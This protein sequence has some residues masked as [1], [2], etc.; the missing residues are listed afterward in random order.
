MAGKYSEAVFAPVLPKMRAVELIINEI[1]ALSPNK[2][3]DISR[4]QVLEIELI[5][6]QGDNFY[7]QRSYNK[8]LDKFREARAKIYKLLYPPFDIYKF[9]VSQDKMLPNTIA[10][11]KKIT[12]MSDKM[13]NMVLPSLP[14]V[15][16]ATGL[17]VDPQPDNIKD[18]M[19]SGLREN[20]DLSDEL[21]YSA[22]NGAAHMQNRNYKAAIEVMEP[23][24]KKAQQ[25]PNADGNL[26]AALELNLAIANLQSDQL[27]N[28]ETLAKQAQTNFT[29]LKDEVG[30]SQAIHM[31][32]IIAQ[33]KGDAINSKKLLLQASDMIK[34][35][36]GQTPQPAGQPA[37]TAQPS[38]PIQPNI[39]PTLLTLR[40]ERLKP[41]IEFAKP[42]SSFNMG[43]A[44]NATT[45]WDQL[46]DIQDMKTNAL[47][48]RIPGRMY[49]WGT[50]PIENAAIKDQT[51]KSWMVGISAGDKVIDFA[52]GTK[53]PAISAQIQ[54]N[55]YEVRKSAVEFKAIRWVISDVLS[56]T[57]YLTQLYSY[58]LPV[59]IGD[60]FAELG[61]YAKAE[62]YYLQAAGYSYINKNIEGV[63][64]WLKIARNCLQ[65]G[66]SLY[67][68]EKLPDAKIQYN[69]II[70]NGGAVPNSKLYTLPSLSVASTQATTLIQKI[71]QRPLPVLNFEISFIVL[72]A[73][74]YLLQIE[75]NL[76]FYGLL[77]SP[78]HTF[79]YLQNVARA[80]AQQAIQ[81]ERE[82]VNFKNREE[83]EA[84]T[85]RELETAA[86]MAKA[87]VD[88][89]LEQWKSAQEDEQAASAALNLSKQRRDNAKAQ[90]DA[91]AA[92][93][94]DQIWGQAASMALSGGEDAYWSEI[95]EL[96]EQTRSG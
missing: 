20:V 69:K 25:T 43:F 42:L 87:E 93:S 92:S 11:E 27:A 39:S 51:S 71:N 55:I 16:F 68:D 15:T 63:Q 17:A 86:A 38:A 66:N 50:L 94:W 24:L 58:V 67:K 95:K 29:T 83:M 36:A 14:L 34:K 90:R 19:K 37:V 6:K 82:Y 48:F 32:G 75:D 88:A 72:T 73:N 91:Y 26:K 44:I 64:L 31:L 59:K 8:A 96:V 4:K 53:T 46:R 56:T 47:S 79:E 22:I 81:A 89:R 76:D 21:Q 2:A 78:I 80:Q 7:R 12:E 40:T 61:S 62:D 30:Q 23:A 10:L 77:L 3:D 9:I 18:F 45:E 65:W 74:N 35:A 33:K 49:G 57:F 54:A 52:V 85:R 28:A 84:A 70:G 13:A 41:T 60:C 1:E 5:I